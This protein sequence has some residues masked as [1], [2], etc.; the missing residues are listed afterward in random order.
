MSVVDVVF[1]ELRG[2]RCALPVAHVREVAS[3]PNLT[4]VP[5]APPSVRGL[6]PLHGQ[7][8]PLL[9]LGVWLAAG[10]PLDTALVRT[11]AAKV[12]VMET[13]LPTGGP[14]VRVA[15]AVDKVSRLGTINEQHSRPPP[16]G[17]R[18]VAASVVDGDGPALLLDAAAIIEQ[19]R[20]AITS[21][22]R[23]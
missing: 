13:R 7:V 8:L 3:A 10:D 20:N 6:A 21:T 14:P 17:P 1:F 2:R 15:L 18:F 19:V 9:D 16:P 4:P 12:L 22:V 23:A 5:L 11:G